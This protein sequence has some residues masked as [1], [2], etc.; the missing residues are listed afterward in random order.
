MKAINYFF[1]L[2][3]EK[4]NLLMPKINSDSNGVMNQFLHMIMF[5]SL[6]RA[7]VE[8]SY[9]KK[10]TIFFQEQMKKDQEN[11]TFHDLINLAEK[12]EQNL[13]KFYSN[14]N[15]RFDMYRSYLL[16]KNCDRF[17]DR[18][19]VTQATRTMISLSISMRSFLK[20]NPIVYSDILFILNVFFP[21]SYF[22]IPEEL[23]ARDN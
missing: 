19:Q 10:I 13:F 12:N 3:K 7:I 14:F 2:E 5:M 20:N 8:L 9:G 22:F 17:T 1:L 4:F 23:L 21:E 15:F 16:L 6:V 18:S 11:Q